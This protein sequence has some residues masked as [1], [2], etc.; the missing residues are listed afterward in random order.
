MLLLGDLSIIITIHS[1]PKKLNSTPLLEKFEEE[2]GSRR[3]KG[4]GGESRYH[5]PAFE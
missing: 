2:A 1:F 4:L 5:L 3:S